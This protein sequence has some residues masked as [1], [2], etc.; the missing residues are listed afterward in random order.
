M[1]GFPV[2]GLLLGLD[3][4]YGLAGWQWLFILEAVPAIILAFVVWFYLTD[5]PRDAHWLAADGGA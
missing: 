5:R 1:I 4:V 2:S 3:G